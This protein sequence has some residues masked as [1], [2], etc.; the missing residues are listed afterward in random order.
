MNE[1]LGYAEWEPP[2]EVSRKYLYNF[3]TFW[4]G[5]A[6]NGAPTGYGDDRH[7]CLVSGNRGGK[8]TH[9]QPLGNLLHKPDDADDL[10]RERLLRVA[11]KHSAKTRL[12]ILPWNGFVESSLN[13]RYQVVWY[14]RLCE[15]SNRIQL[16]FVEKAV[17]KRAC[18]RE[19]R[20]K[21]HGYWMR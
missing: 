1:R 10:R 18:W 19:A 20:H 9:G 15:E 12:G 2:P 13:N 16:V 11:K 14:E 21:H 8:G 6:E 3:Q 17:E 5:C 7:I 4:L